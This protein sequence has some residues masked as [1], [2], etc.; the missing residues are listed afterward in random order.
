M[1]RILNNNGSLILNNFN[2][3]NEIALFDLTNNLLYDSIYANMFTDLN[4]SCSYFTEDSVRV[5][6]NNITKEYLSFFSVNIQSIASKYGE[7]VNFI[8]NISKNKC[9]ID[10]FSLQETWN[11]NF[12]NFNLPGFKIFFSARTNGSRGGCCIYVKDNIDAYQIIDPKLFI[13]NIIEST[14]ISVNINNFKFLICSLYRPNCHN[15]LNTNAQIDSFLDNFNTML[16]FLDTFS[17]PVIIQGDFNINLFHLSEPNSHANQLMD[18]VTPLGYIQ[19]ISKATRITG[20]SSTLIDCTFI[21]DL[22][23]KHIFSGVV[24]TDFSDHFTTFTTISTDK[25]KKKRLPVP[26]K[27]LINSET[28][29][30]FL[31]SLLALSWVE[32]LNLEDTDLSY[33]KFFEIFIFYYNLNFPFVIHHNNIS[34]VPRNPFMSRG[35]LRCRKNKENLSKIAKLYPTPLNINKYNRYRNIYFKSVRTSKKLY[36]RN[37]LHQAL[38]NS[39]KTWSVIKESLN[40][41]PKNSN[42]N[43]IIVD[44]VPITDNILIANKFNEY[45]SNIGPLLSSSLPITTQNFEDYLP[46]PSERSFFMPPI[47]EATMLNYILSTKPKLGHDVNL[48]SMRTLHDVALAICKPLTHIFNLSIESGTFPHNM[49]CSRGIPIYKKGSPL[50]LNNYRVVAMINS[51]SK[52]FEKI[53]SDRLIL[54]FEEN[55]F[56]TKSQ[57]GFRKSTNTQ[58]AL[59][60]IINEITKRLNDSKHVLVLCLDIQKC[61]DSVDREILYRKL[62][63]AGIRGQVLEWIKSYFTNRTQRIFLNGINSSNIC[64]LIL[65]VLQGSILGVIFFLVYINDIPHASDLLLS[66]LF[67]DDNTCLLS[68]N[69]LQELLVSA[70]SELDKLLHWY[71]SNR[72]V[73]HPSKT[74]AFIYRPPRTNLELNVDTN[75]RTFLPIFLNMN[76][77]NEHDLTKII[78]INLVPN[79]EEDSVRLLGIQIDDKLNFKAHFKY[80]HSKVSKAVFSLKIMKHLLDRLHLKLL[81]N[82]YLRSA[83]DYGAALFTTASKSTLKH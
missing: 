17:L 61:F 47:S 35:L 22:I 83:L 31:N 44:D 76:N 4:L 55:N 51:F 10:F 20:H 39:K 56:F 5:E 79:P 80:L 15:I 14:V 54:F 46:P 72:L 7:L 40:I 34:S 63:N 27:R 30:S 77:S 49:K 69:N 67:A 64:D 37:K 19:C 59:S 52:V 33:D 58:H 29:T 18:L 43:K 3:F 38:G 41:P 71:T 78:P 16:N 13:N 82:A 11:D 50:S 23:P 1:V 57:F 24:S 6:L 65:G 62:Q 70:N 28:K 60:A 53:W 66:M 2:D 68:A 48:I 32:V 8:S 9:K 25:V 26:K 81:Y 12:S 45:F 73:L 74:K 42:I 36:I 21:K 75:G